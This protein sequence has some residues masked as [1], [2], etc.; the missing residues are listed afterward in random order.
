MDETDRRGSDPSRRDGDAPKVDPPIVEPPDTLHMLV[1]D[2]DPRRSAPP[3]PPGPRRTRHLVTVVVAA[4]L[5]AAVVGLSLSRERGDDVVE[6]P[7]TPG[8]PV[9]SLWS[10]V[11]PDAPAIVPATPGRATVEP[12]LE[13]VDGVVVHT[14]RSRVGR[15][16]AVAQRST[17]T[18]RVT[19]ERQIEKGTQPVVVA[20]SGVV[21]GLSGRWLTARNGSRELV[22]LAIADGAVMWEE[23]IGVDFAGWIDPSGALFLSGNARCGYLDPQSGQPLFLQVARTCVPA[24]Q[25]LA[26]DS[27]DGWVVFDALGQRV[28]VV[29]GSGVAPRLIGQRVVSTHGDDLRVV[30]RD[31]RAT[32]VHGPRLDRLADTAVDADHVAA[33]SG[34]D[35]FVVDLATP[36]LLGPF[37][38][39]ALPVVVDDEL[40]VVDDGSLPVSELVASGTWSRSPD[41]SDVRV[42]DARGDVV[43]TRRMV[44]APPTLATADGVLLWQQVGTDCTLGLYGY[45][46]LQPIWEVS[47]RGTP[48]AGLASSD[49]LVVATYLDRG[50]DVRL[51]G[52]GA[53]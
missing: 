44:L 52:L 43:A 2:T 10:V 33:W 50:G 21:A 39:T 15:V 22:G 35:Q 18:G 25:G 11:V 1:G 23:P 24:G 47:F 26:Q 19:W 6:L 40:L 31:G 53:P 38:T 3:D 49:G 7:G 48:L 20:S 8:S 29:E 9:A 45:D 34:E 4:A 28:A 16:T 17:A 36:R 14:I 5:V 32:A 51:V 37:A 42:R 12:T 46:D 27:P 30:D 13:I 41:A